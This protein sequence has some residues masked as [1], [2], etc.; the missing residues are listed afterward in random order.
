MLHKQFLIVNSKESFR[1]FQRSRFL[2]DSTE[3][4]ILTSSRLTIFKNYSD[5][6]KDVIFYNTESGHSKELKHNIYLRV[7]LTSWKVRLYSVKRIQL[8]PSKELLCLTKAIISSLQKY[9][10]R[11]QKLENWEEPYS[12]N[13]CCA[14]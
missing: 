4:I 2:N 3:V 11:P 8:T 14:Q 13:L 12:Y 1:D 6:F 10:P 9:V 5:A 7:V